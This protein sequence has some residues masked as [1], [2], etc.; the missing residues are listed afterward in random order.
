MI[1]V[2][3]NYDFTHP[4]Y[5]VSDPIKA[6][7]QAFKY[8]GYLGMLYISKRKNKKYVVYDPFKKKYIHFGD[9]NYMDYLKHQDP[10][11]QY[12]YKKRASKI[13][14]NWKNNKYSPN[15]L[16]LNILW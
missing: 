9:I 16:S 8:L 6:Q 2:L 13:K 14:G 15:N 11:R 5:Q 10:Y 7:Q 1:A 3:F 4:I 12:L